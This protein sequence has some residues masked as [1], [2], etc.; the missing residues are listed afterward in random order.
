MAQNRD[1]PYFINVLEEE[2]DE[3]EELAA[4]YLQ[5]FP[6]RVPRQFRDRSNPMEAYNDE[7]FRVRFRVTKPVAIGM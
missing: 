1:N 3:Y 2:D 7:E 6:P 5:Q 4:E